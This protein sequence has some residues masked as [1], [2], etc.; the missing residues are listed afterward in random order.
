MFSF[1]SSSIYIGKN[2]SSWSFNVT[3]LCTFEVLTSNFLCFWS[4]ESEKV[5]KRQPFPWVFVIRQKWG[6]TYSLCFDTLQ[7]SYQTHVPPYLQYLNALSCSLQGWDWFSTTLTSKS[8]TKSFVVVFSPEER[9]NNNNKHRKNKINKN[10]TPQLPRNRKPSHLR[11]AGWWPHFAVTPP[12]FHPMIDFS[13]G[14]GGGDGDRGLVL[15]SDLLW[16]LP[17]VNYI[18][19]WKEVVQ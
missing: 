14:G 8:G 19:V 3:E 1:T 10:V 13:L 7:L 18:G 5:C 4:F 12:L 17:E 2:K 11:C 9:N 15:W 16:D 6:K